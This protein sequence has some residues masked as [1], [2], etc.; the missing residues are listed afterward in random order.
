MYYLFN[1][2][3]TENI[4]NK[5]ERGKT[6]AESFK[7]I[8]NCSKLKL[9]VEREPYNFINTVDL[10]AFKI[11]YISYRPP[12]KFPFSS[13]YTHKRRINSV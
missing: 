10:T 1:D 9:A 12:S 3:N 13:V 11:H 4:Y 8:E 2:P 7:A 5:L 6:S